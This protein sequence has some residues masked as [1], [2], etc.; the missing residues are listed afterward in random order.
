MIQTS[1]HRPTTRRTNR[2][3]FALDALEAREVCTTNLALNTVANLMAVVQMGQAG[4]VE[5]TPAPVSGKADT[6]PGL[7]VVDSVITL[8]NSTTHT[9][10]LTVRWDGSA[11][12]EAYTLLP[13]Q[14]Q[15]V[16]Y[17]EVERVWR[18]RPQGQLPEAGMGGERVS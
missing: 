8:R 4:P 7:A 11:A 1:T 15:R 17:R 14:T 13:G 5:K 3:R 18:G 10:Q 12:A 2:I 16:W 6:N 9:L